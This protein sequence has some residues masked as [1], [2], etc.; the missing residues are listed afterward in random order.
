MD[1]F[2]AVEVTPLMALELAEERACAG[3]LA[4]RKAMVRAGA[5]ARSMGRL[6]TEQSRADYRRSHTALVTAH[7]DATVRCQAAYL[8]YQRARHRFDA[9]W[10]A[11][12]GRVRVD[13]A[14]NA[15]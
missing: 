7:T 5:L 14:T 8:A 3:Y 4:A 15:H 2:V 1:S 11:T 9:M 6:A 13:R 10:T 12:V